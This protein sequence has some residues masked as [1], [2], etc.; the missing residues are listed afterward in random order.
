M[1]VQ[2]EEAYKEAKAFMKMLMPSHAKK[3]Q[4]YKDTVPLFLQHQVEAEVMHVLEPADGLGAPRADAAK[5]ADGPQDDQDLNSF[6]LE[7]RT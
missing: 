5:D 4:H 7:S 1:L 6:S 2:G 3:V